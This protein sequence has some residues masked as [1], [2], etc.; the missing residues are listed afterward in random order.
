[1]T[2]LK[3]DR[4]GRPLEILTKRHH[5][6]STKTFFRRCWRE[7]WIERDPTLPI[8]LPQIEEQDVNLVTTEEKG[9]RNSA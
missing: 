5:V 2:S 4:T 9:P 6:I 8:V 7:G 3:H 1:M